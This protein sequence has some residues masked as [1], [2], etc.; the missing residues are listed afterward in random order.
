MAVGF[1]LP[2]VSISFEM[3]NENVRLSRLQREEIYFRCSNWRGWERGKG[4]GERVVC[5]FLKESS[6]RRRSPLVPHLSLGEFRFHLMNSPSLQLQRREQ[7]AISSAIL[8]VKVNKVRR[9]TTF[10]CVCVL[11]Y[12]IK[13]C[14]FMFTFELVS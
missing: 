9:G 7:R 8:F 13:W 3:T 12:Y 5:Q 11:L 10:F 4:G 2:L 14:L 6:A 1:V